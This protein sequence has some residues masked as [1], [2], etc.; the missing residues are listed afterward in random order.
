MFFDR[1]DP[2][3]IAVILARGGSN[4]VKNKNIKILGSKPLIGWTIES[5]LASG[6]FSRVVVSTD[7]QEIAKIASDFGAEVPF[8]RPKA[9]ASAESKSID[10][11]LH[12]I[13]WLAAHSTLPDGVA[14]LQP[15]TPFRSISDIKQAVQKFVESNGRQ[16]V[17]CSTVNFPLEWMFLQDPVSSTIAP[18]VG[19]SSI[20]VRSQEGTFTFRLNGAFYLSSVARLL[21]TQSFINPDTV[22]IIQPEGMNNFD[23]DTQSDWDIAERHAENFHS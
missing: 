17:S 1:N 21:E 22:P 13:E 14:L 6:M 9:L 23:I 4:R 15:T 3:I 8:L 7:S 19:W 18:V 12:C 20:S 10:A 11:M 5:A 2:N 16:V